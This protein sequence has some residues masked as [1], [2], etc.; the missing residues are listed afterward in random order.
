MINL[1]SRTQSRK[2][3]FG[4][5]AI[6]IGLPHELNSF[7]SQL[8]RPMHE[9]HGMISAHE[10]PVYYFDTSLSQIKS[11]SAWDIHNQTLK[12]WSRT[13]GLQLHVVGLFVAT[14]T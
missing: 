13:V 6:V 5:D 3:L 10:S 4:C 9:A 14:Y 8:D 1:C 12:L 11:D 2:E 7:C